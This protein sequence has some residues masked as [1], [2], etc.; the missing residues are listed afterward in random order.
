[1][2]GRPLF[3]AILAIICGVG[4][5]VGAILSLM[6]SQWVL[7]AACVGAIAI[8]VGIWRLWRWAWWVGFAILCGVLIWNFQHREI[9][10]D[11]IWFVSVGLW[12]YFIVVFKEY[13]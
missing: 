13:N 3:A 8:C 5:A 1:M 9:I 6:E 7:M 4:G 11:H 12:I 10:N 2:G